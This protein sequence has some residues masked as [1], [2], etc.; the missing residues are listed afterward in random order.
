[1][2]RIL[3]F[4]Q[5]ELLMSSI[6][7]KIFIDGKPVIGE[8]L[9]PF[10]IA[11]IGTNHDCD[12][13]RAR[14]MIQRVAETGCDCVKFQIYEPD[15]IVSGRVTT[16]DYGLSG[17]YG[18]IS[19]VQ[20]FE[21]YLKTPKQWFPELTELAHELGLKCAATIHG[22]NGIHWAQ[23]QNFDI[24]KIA[25][26]DHTNLPLFESMV[27]KLKVP[28]LL[29]LGMAGVDD[30]DRAM[31]ILRHHT[32]GVGLFYCV[33]VYPPGPGDIALNN[34]HYL[35]DRYS[36]PVGFSDHTTNITTACSALAFGA[37]MFEKH[38]THDRNAKG[39][40][41]PFALEFNELEQYVAAIKEN[42]GFLGGAGF[43]PPSETVDDVYLARPG[44]G[45]QPRYLNQVIDS[46]LLQDVESETP[47]QWHDFG[48]EEPSES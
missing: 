47:L 37:T 29:S 40:D 46:V 11:E 38:V 9:S 48:R 44:T 3:N 16:A 39:P 4:Y 15:E 27:E 6:E 7:Q 2:G 14:E 26:M 13:G 18:D 41:H 28:L 33:A 32:P 22:E 45:I 17:V 36:V 12:L 43:R 31:Q 1:M 30:A 5:S 8:G 24:I 20:M 21:D 23:D 19:A 42:S 25:S 35:A 10:I 34:I